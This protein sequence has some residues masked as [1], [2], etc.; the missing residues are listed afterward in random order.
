MTILNLTTCL[1]VAIAVLIVFFS[2]YLLFID[3]SKSIVATIFSMN[4]LKI[5]VDL[6]K[7][8]VG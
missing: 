8:N 3:H 5:V 1:F 2:A 7:L 6:V 4:L